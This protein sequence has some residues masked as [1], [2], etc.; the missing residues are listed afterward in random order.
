MGA[1]NVLTTLSQNQPLHPTVV[2]FSTYF[3]FFSSSPEKGEGLSPEILS[4]KQICSKKRSSELISERDYHF[5]L[6]APNHMFRIWKGGGPTAP[7]LRWPI[8]VEGPYCPKV[9][10]Q[11]WI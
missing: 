3:L 1:E 5:L 4:C 7:L 10:P 9:S 8:G 6:D 2:M 11:T